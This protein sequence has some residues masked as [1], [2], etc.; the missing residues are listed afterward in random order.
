MKVLL[1][2]LLSL[3]STEILW[4]LEYDSIGIY[5]I[6]STLVFLERVQVVVAGLLRCDGQ[7]TFPSALV[8]CLGLVRLHSTGLAVGSFLDGWSLPFLNSSLLSEFSSHSYQPCP[9]WYFPVCL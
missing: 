8:R 1:E 4:E 6:Y 2:D 7:E 3:E 5:L 9:S